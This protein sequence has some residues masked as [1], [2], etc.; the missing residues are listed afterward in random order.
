MDKFL[1][2]KSLVLQN[3]SS[4]H[5]RIDLNNILLDTKLWNNFSSFNPND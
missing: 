2:R 5:I 3:S 4:K 1:I